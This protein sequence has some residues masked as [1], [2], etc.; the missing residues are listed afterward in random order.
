[1]NFLGVEKS[2]TTTYHPQGNGLVERMNRSL[3]NLLRCFVSEN[4]DWE[5]SLGPVLYAY[6]TAIHSSTGF[7]PYEIM[8]AR[9][10]RPLLD[11]QSHQDGY[12]PE[13]WKNMFKERYK[14]ILELVKQNVDYTQDKQA[15]TYNK[16]ARTE[17][18]VLEDEV[19]VHQR[20]RPHKFAPL[21]KRGWFVKK[22]I[23]PQNVI[24]NDTN[25]REIVIHREKIRKVNN[26]SGNKDETSPYH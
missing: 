13:N 20:F 18:L 3:L 26:N 12:D 8:F 14:K 22:V 24:I 1:M 7:S 2:H 4:N 21:W 25:G 15:Y 23:S 17:D 16:T 10:P 19:W 11:D 5:D 6:R 9:N